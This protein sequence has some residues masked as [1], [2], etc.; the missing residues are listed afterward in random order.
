MSLIKT[1]KSLIGTES[2]TC[3]A[4]TGENKTNTCQNE[5]FGRGHTQGYDVQYCT[6][7]I[8]SKA[9]PYGGRFGC[10]TFYISEEDTT[11]DVN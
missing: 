7:H 1:L 3:Q 4:V 2:D 11:I 10:V 6:E 9:M 8:P 5:V